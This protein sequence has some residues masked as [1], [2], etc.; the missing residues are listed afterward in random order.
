M[1]YVFKNIDEETGVVSYGF[2]PEDKINDISK[3]LAFKILDE[4]PVAGDEL[5][6]KEYALDYNELEDLFF[7]VPIRDLPIVEE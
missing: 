3:E 2:V 7:W 4:L 1:I 6:G 5:D